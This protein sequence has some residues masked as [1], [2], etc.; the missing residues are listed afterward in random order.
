M[1]KGMF[2]KGNSGFTLMEIM[3]VII[4]IAVL[5]SVAGPMIGTITDQGKSAA[6]KSSM[7]NIKTALI[8]F[9]NDFSRFPHI[10]PNFNS[11]GVTA[12]KTG[13]MA[14]AY[15]NNI[16]VNNTTFPAAT[17]NMGMTNPTFLKRWKGPYMDSTAEEFMNDSWGGQIEYSHW[18]G[19]IW[20]HSMGADGVR[21][22]VAEAAQPGYFTAETG[23]DDIVMSV[24][25]TKFQ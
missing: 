13:M 17:A 22:T 23:N 14:P 18:N 15:A 3:V 10:G 4:V 19:S 2:T 1:R 21:N 24:T 6:T 12:A 20:L 25:R 5:A 9:S 11:W 16:L 7:T 8:N